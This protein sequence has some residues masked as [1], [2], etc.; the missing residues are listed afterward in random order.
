LGWHPNSG[1]TIGN[2]WQ[3]FRH[4]FTSG[5]IIF[6]VRKD[7]NLLWYSYHGNGESDRSGT[8]GWNDNS[9]NQIG[10][11]WQDFR[12]VFGGVNDS[13]GWGT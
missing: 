5:D 4:I 11:G 7:G 9:G 10:N 3:N 1:N 2:G 6:S 8:L 12:A 13:G